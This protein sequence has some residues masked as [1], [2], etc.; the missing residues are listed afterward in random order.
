[1]EYLLVFNLPAHGC[2]FNNWFKS[3]VLNLRTFFHFSIK[4]EPTEDTPV[5]ENSHKVITVESRKYVGANFH[6]L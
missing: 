3:V 4:K 5:K 2:D 6:G 1:M